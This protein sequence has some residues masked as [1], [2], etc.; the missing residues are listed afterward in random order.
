[1]FDLYSILSAILRSAAHHADCHVGTRPRVEP[2]TGNLEAG[3]LTISPPR[4]FRKM[5]KPVSGTYTLFSLK[6]KPATFTRG[7]GTKGQSNAIFDP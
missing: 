7:V 5:L 2:G 3:T 1:M 6:K 4:L